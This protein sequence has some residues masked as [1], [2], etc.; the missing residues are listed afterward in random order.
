MSVIHGHI[1]GLSAALDYG[2]G[3]HSLYDVAAKLENGHAQLWRSDNAVIITQVELLPR[4]KV[5]HFW[6]ATGELDEV[7]A[8]SE[9]VIEWAKGIGCTR[10]SLAGRKGWVKPLAS[11]G[12]SPELVVLGRDI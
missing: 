10:A 8:L 3:T 5:V 11:R 4:K 12:W 9:E 7:I 1:E 2:G 6:L